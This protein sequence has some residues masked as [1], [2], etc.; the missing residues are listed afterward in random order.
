MGYDAWVDCECARQGAS[1]PCPHPMSELASAQVNAWGMEALRELATINKLGALLEWLPT[2]NGGE[3]PLEAL[4]GFRAELASLLEAPTRQTI[5]EDSI[6]GAELLRMEDSARWWWRNQG[7]GAD[8]EGGRVHIWQPDGRSASTA[9]FRLQ[10]GDPGTLVPL[11][12]ASATEFAWFGPELAA[13]VRCRAETIASASVGR[14]VTE[15]LRVVDAGLAA[16][17]RLRWG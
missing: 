1:T 4:P 9:H 12:A 13:E 5:L 17:Q 8:V 16:G 7:H 14:D 15:L 6:T 10:A 3:V 11:D 2:H